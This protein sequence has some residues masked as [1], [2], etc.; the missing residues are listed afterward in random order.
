MID[1]REIESIELYVD[2]ATTQEL[3]VIEI[4]KTQIILKT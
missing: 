3:I 1:V 2:V 4:A